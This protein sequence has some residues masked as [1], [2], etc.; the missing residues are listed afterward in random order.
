MSYLLLFLCAFGAYSYH[1][2][3]FEFPPVGVLLYI[4]HVNMNTCFTFYLD[5]YSSSMCDVNC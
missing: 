5:D 1:V 3:L 2:S 4:R